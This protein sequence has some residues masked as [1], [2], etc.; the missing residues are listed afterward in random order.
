MCVCVCVCTNHSEQMT[1]LVTVEYSATV[2]LC[3][4]HDC[5]PCHMI[6]PRKARACVSAE[7]QAG[8]QGE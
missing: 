8:H 2:D 1:N 3:L 7:C 6:L 4:L 5:W